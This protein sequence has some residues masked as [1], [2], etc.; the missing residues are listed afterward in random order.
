M[1]WYDCLVIRLKDLLDLINNIG[2]TRCFDAM[3]RIQVYSGLCCVQV[4]AANNVN[5]NLQFRLAGSTFVNTCPITVNNLLAVIPATT[6]GISVSFSIARPPNYKLTITG[7]NP[8]DAG[9][10]I[11]MTALRYYHSPIIFNTS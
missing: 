9:A 3:L 2:L 10:S 11:L 6:A 1:I 7:F 5:A 4:A 8:S